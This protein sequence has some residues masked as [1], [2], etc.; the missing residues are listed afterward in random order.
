MVRVENQKWRN[1]SS[2]FALRTDGCGPPAFYEIWGV[3]TLGLNIWRWLWAP[4]VL[5][6]LRCGN[7]GSQYLEVHELRS[8]ESN[9][10]IDV[11]DRRKLN[12]KA[13]ADISPILIWSYLYHLAALSCD[14]TNANNDNWRY[15][16]SSAVAEKPRDAPR[17]SKVSV[18]VETNVSWPNVALQMCTLSFCILKSSSSLF[19]L[20]IL[21]WPWLILHRY[22]M[23]E[24]CVSITSY[25]TASDPWPWPD[26]NSDVTVKKYS[27]PHHDFFLLLLT[28]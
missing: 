14:L 28:S 4:S 26:L 13:T 19:S 24:I 11:D 9:D 23:S 12:N 10:T 25:A 21:A 6:N 22:S 27:S 15:T 18:R 20:L 2:A 7:A 17:N 16:G 5:W 1:C 3:G 8:L